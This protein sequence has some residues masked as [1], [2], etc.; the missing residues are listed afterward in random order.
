MKGVKGGRGMAE[1]CRERRDHQP[2]L[3]REVGGRESQVRGKGK[4]LSTES[5]NVSSF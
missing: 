1:G 3:V 5:V 2:H 4:G